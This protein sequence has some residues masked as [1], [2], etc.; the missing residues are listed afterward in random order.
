MECPH[1]ATRGR[2]STHER[3]HRH[4]MPLWSDGYDPD[5]SQQ[6][7]N[8]SDASDDD[9]V[10]HALAGDSSDGELGVDREE[11]TTHPS[12][13]TRSHWQQWI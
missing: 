2:R 7:W 11:E 10:T 9:E 1:A 6:V 12:N 13:D 4:G 8:D 3:P 5:F